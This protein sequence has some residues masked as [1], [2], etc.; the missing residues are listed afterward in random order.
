[1]YGWVC[2]GRGWTRGL[3]EEVGN[4]GAKESVGPTE[5]EGIDSSRIGILVELESKSSRAVE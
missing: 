1:V 5:T 4:D 3:S 2:G